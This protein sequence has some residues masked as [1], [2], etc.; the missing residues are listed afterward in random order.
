MANKV[1]QF[2]ITLKDIKPVIW[3]RILVQ[4]SYSFWD[5]HVAIQDAMGWLDCHLLSFRMKLKHSRKFTEIG[6]PDED[7]FEGDPEGLPGWEIRICDYFL[8]VG[9]TALYEYDFGDG[10]EHEV[11]LEGIVLREK[12]QKYPKCIDGARACP[13]E[14][15]GGIPG[16]YHVL[17]VIS[18]PSHEEYEEMV[19]WLGR[20]YDPDEF[21]PELIKFDNPRQRWD[22]AFSESPL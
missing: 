18:D 17:E 14:D 10:W 11:V 21:A 9:F 20:K 22:M 15:C 16:Y 7:R 8:D 2:K 3:R 6:I 5:L 12:G 1:F 19:T 4:E 13:P